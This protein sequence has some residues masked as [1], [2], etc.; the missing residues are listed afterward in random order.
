MH[1][2][3]ISSNFVTVPSE[4]WYYFLA[5]VF[6]EL[7]EPRLGQLAVRQLPALLAL[8]STQ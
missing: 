4:H 1:L 7:P 2:N 5:A 3:Q 6:A 8:D